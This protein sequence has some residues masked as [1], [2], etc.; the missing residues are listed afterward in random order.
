MQRYFPASRLVVFMTLN[1]AMNRRE[2]VT[3]IS[4][5]GASRTSMPCKHGDGES[6]KKQY[7][8]SYGTRKTSE[9]TEWMLLMLPP[10][11]SW[12]H[13]LLTM[14]VVPGKQVPRN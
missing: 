14:A 4:F 3:F 5:R 8:L 6:R 9:G 1:D 13:G 11:R 10:Y 7:Q 2:L 12:F